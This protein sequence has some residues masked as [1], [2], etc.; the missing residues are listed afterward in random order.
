MASKTSLSRT[1][2]RITI[3]LVA[4]ILVNYIERSNLSVAAP[5]IKAEWG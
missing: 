5:A 2:W 3:L 4:S 1:E